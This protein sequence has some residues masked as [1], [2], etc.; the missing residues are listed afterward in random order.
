MTVSKQKLYMFFVFLQ[1][2]CSFPISQDKEERCRHVLSYVLKASFVLLS[3]FREAVPKDK[4]PKITFGVWF[5]AQSLC[6]D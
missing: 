4:V 6:M 5:I 2:S 3:I 1:P